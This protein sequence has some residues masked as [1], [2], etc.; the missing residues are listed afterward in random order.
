MRFAFVDENI[1][2]LVAKNQSVDYEKRSHH[3]AGPDAIEIE[4]DVEQDAESN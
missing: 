4:N 1:E 3:S 2:E